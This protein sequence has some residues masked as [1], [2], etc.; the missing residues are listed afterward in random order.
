MFIRLLFLQSLKS[1]ELFFYILSHSLYFIY[2][3]IDELNFS[4]R[5]LIEKSILKIKRF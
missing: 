3:N 5:S 2:K 4:F 1:F